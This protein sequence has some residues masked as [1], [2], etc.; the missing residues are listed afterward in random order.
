MSETAL[1]RSP[2]DIQPDHIGGTPPNEDAEP[3]T[4]LWDEPTRT[5]NDWFYWS[6]NVDSPHT[7]VSSSDL[8]RW[9]NSFASS[10][11]YFY[12]QPTEDVQDILDDEQ[13]ETYSNKEALTKT[14]NDRVTL[15]ARKY[16]ND[17]TEEEL[18]RFE[19]LT[20][21]LEKLKPRV[22]DADID[23]LTH[24]VETVEKLNK[25]KNDLKER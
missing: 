15:L 19:I 10:I 18:S 20:Q 3:V 16:V 8:Q 7:F 9:E 4:C 1:E 11:A 24:M 12:I 2:Y 23:N 6:Q 22:T 13:R 5:F 25:I 21:R 14:A 17:L